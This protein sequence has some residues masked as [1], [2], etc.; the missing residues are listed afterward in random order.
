M[1]EQNPGQSPVPAWRNAPKDGATGHSPGLAERD[2]GES[3]AQPA[4]GSRP[5]GL[6]PDS[7]RPPDR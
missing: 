2:T 3:E 4:D 5:P 6:S 7:Y 1:G